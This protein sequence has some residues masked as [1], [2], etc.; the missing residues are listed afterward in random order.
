M[1]LFVKKRINKMKNKKKTK[2]KENKRTKNKR[3]TAASIA[4][5]LYHRWRWY[6]TI[7]LNDQ[8]LRPTS[9]APLPPKLNDA[10]Q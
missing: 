1:L 4:P 6:Q 2:K 8:H 5:A 3:K 9:L 7:A 10:T